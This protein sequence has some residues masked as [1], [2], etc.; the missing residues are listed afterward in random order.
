MFC[1][2]G[3]GAFVTLDIADFALMVGNPARRI[4]WMSRAGERLG[5]DL[6]CPRTKQK[7]MIRNGILAEA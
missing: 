2:I 4:G 5:D 6:I 1:F 7:Y 3:A